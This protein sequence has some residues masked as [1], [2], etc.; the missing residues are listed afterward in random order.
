MNKL[1]TICLNLLWFIS[2][3]PGYL[4]FRYALRHPERCQAALLSKLLRRNKDTEY[5][6]AHGFAEVRGWD[7]FCLLPLTTE[8]DYRTA[9]ARIMQGRE[10]VLTQDP[11]KILQPTSGTS[12]SPKLIPYTEPMAEQ[13]RAALDAWIVD[14]F[15]QRPKL[16]SGVQ[17]WSLSPATELTPNPECLVTVGFLDDAEYFGSGRRWIMDHLM[18]VPAEVRLIPDMTANQYVTLLFLL[19]T[20]QLRLISVWHPSFLTI[21]LEMLRSM[22]ARCLDDLE[23][24]GIDPGLDIPESI[25]TQLV[26]KL[27]PVPMR[28]ADLKRLNCE[29]NDLYQQVWPN[30]QIIS[31]WRDGKVETEITELESAFPDVLIQGKGLLATEGVVSIP[32]GSSQEQ[33]CALT[34][35][36][37]EFQDEQG[38]V[39]RM[40]DLEAGREYR[41]I[42]TTGAGLCR[43][44]L[45]DRVV[46]TGFRGK[47]PCIRFLG[48]SGVVSDCVGEKLHLE[49]VENVVGEIT[50][51]FLPQS[52]FAML[53]PSTGSNGRRYNFLVEACEN[54][55]PD[56][57]AVSMS[58]E[59]GLCENYHYAHARK[60]GQLE[61]VVVTLVG[62]EAQARYRSFMM[63]DGAIAGTVKFPALCTVSG[64]EEHLVRSDMAS[65]RCHVLERP[66]QQ[67]QSGCRHN[68]EALM[69]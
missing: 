23:N 20:N 69:V 68:E 53:V 37:L 27:K 57:N 22:W 15:L 10:R 36:I 25:R 45:M 44:Q 19:R 64:I 17:Y 41:V 38:A 18:P 28:V 58:L 14:L 60:I 1:C 48:R 33:V 55:N 30:L 46:V 56:L 40:W 4:R 42:L 32:F 16:F 43:Y 21:L 2:S 24:G 11:V 51:R 59:L 5:G 62:P 7:D 49:H 8:E 66:G 3:V 29:A 34:S 54:T 26:K 67:V 63:K 9:I 6:R 61:S 47:T 31:C 12:S 35:H 65:H 52:R 50:R 39:Q 13:F